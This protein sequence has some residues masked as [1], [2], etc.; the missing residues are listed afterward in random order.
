MNHFRKRLIIELSISLLIVL[1]L[2]AGVEFFKGNVGDYSDRIVAARATLSNRAASVGELASL[3]S[4]FNGKASNYLN[5]LHN[6]IPPYDQLINLNK[7]LQSLAVQSNVGYGFSF[8]GEVSKSSGGL[9]SISFNLDA[10]SGNFSSLMS[11]L[12]LVQNLRYL[13]SVDEVSMRSNNATLVM[14]IKA[15]VFYR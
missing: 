9:G 2:F 15:R 11:F 10:S 14:N 5:V 8:A 13:S 12:K 3:R 4:Q 6:I 7:E 1:A